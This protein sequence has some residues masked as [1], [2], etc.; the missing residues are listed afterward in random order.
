MRPARHRGQPSAS[1]RCSPRSTPVRG[2][3]PSAARS[4]RCARTRRGRSSCRASSARA[5]IREGDCIQ[6][7]L[8]QRFDVTPAPE[9][10]SL[11]RA[12]RHVNPSPYLFYVDAGDATLV[13]ASPEP[14]VRVRDG[15]VVMHPIAGT[16]PRGEDEAS[17]LA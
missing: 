15:Q 5:L 2:S 16:R 7:V 4:A 13:G 10:L 11:Y 3:R 1:P 6:V 14:F 17:D 12:V 8:S 9:P